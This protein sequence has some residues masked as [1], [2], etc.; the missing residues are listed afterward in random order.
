MH[1]KIYIYLEVELYDQLYFLVED[2]SKRLSACIKS[3]Y[4]NKNE[5]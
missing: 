1:L 3:R 4:W 2:G 5:G